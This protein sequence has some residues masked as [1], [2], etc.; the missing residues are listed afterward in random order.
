LLVISLYSSELESNSAFFLSSLSIS[1]FKS[2]SLMSLNAWVAA[3][4]GLTLDTLGLVFSSLESESPLE[5]DKSRYNTYT[6]Y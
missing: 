5:L 4:D 3:S 6:E 2:S 1:F